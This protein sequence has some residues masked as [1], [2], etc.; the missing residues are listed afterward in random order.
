MRLLRVAALAVA[1]L[2]SAVSVEAQLRSQVYASGFLSPVGFV[3]DPTD[4]DVQFVLE[5]AGRI[6]VIRQGAVQGTSFLDLTGQISTGGERGLLGLAFAP[7]YVSSARFFVYYTNPQ[8][9]LVIARFKRSS[10]NPLVADVTSRF[11]FRWPGGFPYIDHSAAGNHNGGTLAF[12]S[13][14]Y[15]YAG[16]GDGGGGNDTAHNAQNPNTLL[17]KILR[18]NVDVPE[19]DPEGYDIPPDNPFLDAAPIAALPHIWAFGVRNPWRFSFDEVARGGTGAMV[20]A[21]VGQSRRE[22]INY[23]PAGRGGRNYGWRNREGLLANVTTLPPAYTPLIDPILDY[24]RTNGQSITGGFVYR[25]KKL[26]AFFRGRYF[27]ADFVT[28]RVWSIALTLDASGE[29]RASDMRNHTS[30]LSGGTSVGNVSSFGIDAAG[31]LYIVTYQGSVLKILGPP[32][33]APT[34]VRITRP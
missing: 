23:E 4:P 1:L 5:Q 14:G 18:L 2:L 26:P 15:L 12:G 11:E 30:E 9:H 20:V 13:D 7:D 28:G 22:E 27:F 25:G 29:A 33:A 21:D 6:R 24:D 8:G 31:E 34:G 19:S 10:T 3:Q 32:L 17:G 16:P